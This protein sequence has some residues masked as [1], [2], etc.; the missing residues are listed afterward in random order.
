MSSRN[1]G[2]RTLGIW[3]FRRLSTIQAHMSDLGHTNRCLTSLQARSFKN[4][5]ATRIIR[6]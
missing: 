1:S 2:G 5:F 4:L 6:I 3:R